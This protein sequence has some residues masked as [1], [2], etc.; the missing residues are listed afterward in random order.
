ME[1]KSNIEEFT[2]QCKEK[3]FPKVMIAVEDRNGTL[4]QPSI[5]EPLFLEYSFVPLSRDELTPLGLKVNIRSDVYQ[6]IQENHTDIEVPTIPVGDQD[7]SRT[8]Y[9][10]LPVSQFIPFLSK[11]AL[12]VKIQ[13]VLTQQSNPK[14][15]RVWWQVNE[16]CSCHTELEP[17]APTF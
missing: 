6:W 11:R 2:L 16:I 4:R 10:T 1:L 7:A 8:F 14:L 3:E 15:A 9:V 17:L 5:R 12:T 13:M